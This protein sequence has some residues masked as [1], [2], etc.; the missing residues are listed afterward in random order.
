[1]MSV[2][3]RTANPVRVDTPA[4]FRR[5][6]TGPVAS[7]RPSVR[8]RILNYVLA[9]VTLVLVADALVGDNGL[10]ETL[11]A[12]RQYAEVATSLTQLRQENA[13]V[14]DQIRRLR[15]DPAAIEAIAR[16]ELGLMRPGEVVFVI[17]DTDKR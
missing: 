15:E 5:R 7:S 4:S 2:A 9:L 13:R 17:K 14:R 1:M 11:H 3:D 8:A 6:R 16:E 12:R 10:L